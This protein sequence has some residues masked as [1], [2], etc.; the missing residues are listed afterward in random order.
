MSAVMNPAAYFPASIAVWK[1][2]CRNS[3]RDPLP[4]IYSK[5]PVLSILALIHNIALDVSSSFV[6]S[7]GN[8]WL[9]RKVLDAEDAL[10]LISI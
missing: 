1:E 3:H 2:T 9:L 4:L 5:T 8:I 10:R 6:H 7:V